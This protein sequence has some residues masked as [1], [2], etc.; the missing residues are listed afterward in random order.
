[1]ARA[2]GRVET[3]VPAKINITLFSADAC[4]ASTRTTCRKK[5]VQHGLKGVRIRR[6]VCRSTETVST[7]SRPR[8]SRSRR[9]WYNLERRLIRCRKYFRKRRK[10]ERNQDEAKSS[11]PRV[12]PT[13]FRSTRA[14]LFF[15]RLGREYE[16]YKRAPKVQSVAS[17]YS[18]K[19]VRRPTA[20]TVETCFWSTW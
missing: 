11:P 14:E 5:R 6:L 12:A 7:V 9:E 13:R 18:A 19:I 2:K 1:M 8:S 16:N 15:A 4:Y 3:P 20:F 17:R 10:N